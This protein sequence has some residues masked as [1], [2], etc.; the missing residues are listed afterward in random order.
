MIKCPRVFAVEI[1][2]VSG[3]AVYVMMRWLAGFPAIIPGTEAGMVLQQFAG[4]KNYLIYVLMAA[5][6]YIT[7][8]LIHKTILHKDVAS[9]WHRLIDFA[10]LTIASGVCFYLML[11]F[12][13]WSHIAG[14]TYDNMYYAADM[15][16]GGYNWLNN[17]AASI[18]IDHMLYFRLFAHSMLITYMVFA[19]I[20]FDL[21]ERVVTG[22]ATVAVLGGLAYM[23]AP[24]YGPFIYEPSQGA[25]HETQQVML[26]LT[27]QFKNSGMEGKHRFQ[28]EAVLGAM[29]SLHIAHVL[30][31]TY[32]MFKLWHP[33][34]Y[35]FSLFCVY[36]ALYAVITRFH[37][38]VDLFAGVAVAALAIYV[39][40][41]LVCKLRKS[42]AN[43]PK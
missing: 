19:A 43:Q 13:W 37:Y 1:V 9:P 41:R 40:E 23:I 38:I 11:V 42:E 36:I 29:P 20:R 26:M 30:V 7:S 5:L 33:A 34:G 18:Q 21:L 27:E 15:A 4:T 10:R 14:D 17:I 32:Y 28:I 12:K 16:M 8:Q 25:L 39:T 3:L 22:N 35:L 6:I 31:L 2:A 24:A